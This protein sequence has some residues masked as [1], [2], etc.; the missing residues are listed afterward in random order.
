MQCPHCKKTCWISVGDYHFY[1]AEETKNDKGQKILVIDSS[2]EQ[3]HEEEY[4][5]SEC[6]EDIYMEIEKKFEYIDWQ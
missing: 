5:C 1:S 2:N 4:R 3:H 6:Q